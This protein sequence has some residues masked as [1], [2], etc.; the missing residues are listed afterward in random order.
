MG[1]YYLNHQNYRVGSVIK[2]GA[3]GRVVLN[4]PGHRFLKMEQQFELVRCKVDSSLPSRL[5]CV[6]LFDELEMA[7][8][9]QKLQR[10]NDKL[11]EVRVLDEFAPRHKADM[12][13]VHPE[14]EIWNAQWGNPRLYWTSAN[15]ST[16]ELRE[17]LT[18]SPVQIA[19]RVNNGSVSESSASNSN[20]L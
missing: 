16:T 11:Y 8:K 18:A 3:W 6:F 12:M 20:P 7:T 13:L 4:T 10:P 9:F 1:Y 14:L 17:I 19:K 5:S 15:T 2:P